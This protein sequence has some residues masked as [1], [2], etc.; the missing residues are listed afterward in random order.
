M[1]LEVKISLIRRLRLLGQVSD[2]CSAIATINEGGNKRRNINFFIIIIGCL[3]KTFRILCSSH[4]SKSAGE[5]P[6]SGS[7]AN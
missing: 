7:I 5:L 3:M 1:I 2:H 6:C 4:G